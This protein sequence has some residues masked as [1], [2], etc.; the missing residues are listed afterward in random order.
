MKLTI[1]G[2]GNMGSAIA[3]G[4]VLGSLFKPSDMTVVDVHEAPLTALQA[5]HP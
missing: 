5:T 4:L 2:G 1:I 3:R